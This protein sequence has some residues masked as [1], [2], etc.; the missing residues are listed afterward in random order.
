MIDSGI[1]LTSIQLLFVKLVV[2]DLQGLKPL[3]DTDAVCRG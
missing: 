2:L 3:I 1:W